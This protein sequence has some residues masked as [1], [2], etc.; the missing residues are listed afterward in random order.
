MNEV[1][2]NSVLFPIC[3]INLYYEGDEDKCNVK[4]CNW[5]TETH[6]CTRACEVG[7]A[8]IITIRCPL[9]HEQKS[10][11]SYSVVARNVHIRVCSVCGIVFDPRIANEN[12]S[13]EFKKQK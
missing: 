2:I 11:S 3:P 9:G 7:K 12:V 1:D 4:L 13:E 5:D 10:R 6:S 8:N